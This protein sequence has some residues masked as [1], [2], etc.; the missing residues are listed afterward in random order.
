MDLYPKNKFAVA[1]VKKFIVI[2]YIVAI[3]G[4][5]IPLTND[6]FIRITP[7]ALLLCTYLLAIYH[8]TYS[9]K[10]AFTF[11]LVFL[12]GFIVEVIGVNT[13]L[14]F[15]IYCYG[16][17]LGLK[18]I[19]TPLL[20]GVNWLFLTYTTISITRSFKIKE[21]LI[22]FIAP[23]FMLVFDIILEQVAPKIDLWNWQNSMV[24]IKNYIAWYLI[25]VSFVLLFKVFKIE[26]KNPLAAI[27]FICQLLF[28]VIL[29]FLLK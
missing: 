29:T 17:T 2:F 26:T 4:F 16:R 12:L 19:N 6:L 18:L 9:S 23:V 27:L 20:I 25:G 10:D 15:G 28:F 14:V 7:L 11:I 3:L 5:F 24:T 21:G 22:L 8:E 13:G 1:E